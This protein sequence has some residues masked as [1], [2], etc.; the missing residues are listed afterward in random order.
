MLK[1]GIYCPIFTCTYRVALTVYG[2]SKDSFGRRE[3]YYRTAIILKLNSMFNAYRLTAQY[4]QP[5]NITY[6]NYRGVGEL[7]PGCQLG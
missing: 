2:Y 3:R 4:I 6:Y 5:G 7:L 1:L